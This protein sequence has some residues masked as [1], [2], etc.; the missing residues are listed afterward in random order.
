MDLQE[1]P[2]YEFLATTID[3]YHNCVESNNTDWMKIHRQRIEDNLPKGM[4]LHLDES[5]PDRLKL[6][7]E[8]VGKLKWNEWQTWYIEAV[9]SFQFDVRLDVLECETDNEREG[10]EDHIAETVHYMLTQTI[11]P[12]S[13]E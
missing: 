11:T 4:E 3:A 8:T 9:P 12:I 5:E 1:Q 6:E 7:Y 13:K 10:D 2:L